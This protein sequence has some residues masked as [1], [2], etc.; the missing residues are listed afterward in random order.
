M[1]ARELAVPSQARTG[2]GMSVEVATDMR[3][4]MV[5]AKANCGACGQPWFGDVA[6]CPYCGHDASAPAPRAP[7]PRAPAIASSTAQ[8]PPSARRWTSW[9]KPMAAAAV[10]AV[11]VIGV[12]EL[13]ITRDRPDVPVAIP[14]NVR[15]PAKADV[16]ATAPAVPA[17]TRSPSQAQA[18]AA[19]P[20]PRA[21]RN[22]AP[23]QAPA[24]PAAPSSLCSAANHAAGLCNPQ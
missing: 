21:D 11:V 16:A 7:V 20:P 22:P 23:P 18:P 13:S 9:W 3:A 10:M 19:E 15:A 6:Y 8:K 2:A 1:S 4:G 24:T 17:H 5:R 14:A 12:Q